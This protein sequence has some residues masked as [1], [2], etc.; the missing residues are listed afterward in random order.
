MTSGKLQCVAGKGKR[1]TC[2]GA[3]MQANPASPSCML[4]HTG[5]LCQPRDILAFNLA[6]PLPVL[7]KEGHDLSKKV[8]REPLAENGEP[9]TW[10]HHAEI[11][12][13][14]V[15]LM[16][17]QDAMRRGKRGKAGRSQRKGATSRWPQTLDS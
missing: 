5:L 3:E 14:A 12:K 4:G 1:F 6:L 2:L 9:C 17:Q 15:K 16:A 11:L 13:W 10:D 7:F 8:H